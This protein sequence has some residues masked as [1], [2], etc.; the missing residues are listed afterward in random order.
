M[1]SII[2]SSLIVCTCVTQECN[3]LCHCMV[4]YLWG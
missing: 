4:H 3:R 1:L 2:D